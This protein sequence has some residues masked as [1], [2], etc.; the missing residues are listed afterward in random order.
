[1]MLF[2]SVCFMTVVFNDECQH[3]TGAVCSFL[4]CLVADV[5]CFIANRSMCHLGMSKSSLALED[6]EKAIARD[7]AYVKGYYRRGMALIGLKKYSTARDAMRKGLDLA[8]GDKTFISQL[9]KLRGEAYQYDGDVYTSSSSTPVPKLSTKT[10]P[11]VTQV[12][13]E[14]PVSEDTS[15]SSSSTSSNKT[16]H[17][18]RG[19]KTTSDGRKTTFFNNE[20]DEKTKELIGDITPKAITT[21]VTEQGTIFLL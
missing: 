19:Y 9:D 7:P 21:L 14:T 6:A 3:N 20:M 16:N 12:K 18:M 1:M 4:F 11:P 13:K 17:P 8:P 2:F 5:F 15:S 10:T